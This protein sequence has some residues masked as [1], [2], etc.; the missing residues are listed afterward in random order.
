VS[1]TAAAQPPYAALR[2]AADAWFIEPQ[3]R[4]ILARTTELWRY[5]RVL[6]FL[7]TRSVKQ[8]YEGTTLGMFW[9]FARPLFPILITGLVFGR[10]LGVPSDGLPYILFFMTGVVPWTLFERSILFGTKC[11]EQHRSLIKKLYFPR[12][13]APVASVAPAVVDFGIYMGLV[14]AAALFYLWKDGVLYLRVG[15]SV[16][17]AFLMAA[18]AVLCALSVVLWTCVFQAR[19]RDVRFTMRYVMQFWMYLTPVFYPMSVIAPEY[20]W[21]VYVNPIASIVATFRWALIGAGEVPIGPLLS[22][23]AL[24]GVTMAAGLWF[25][26]ASESETIDRL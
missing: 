7:A 18:L 13:I 15:P 5:R 1:E 10:F 11:L 23:V 8:R 16:V 21:I 17:V 9:L 19:H 26:T 25:F 12:L 14:T 3:R 24:A 6:W 2:D 22:A 4:G 20:R